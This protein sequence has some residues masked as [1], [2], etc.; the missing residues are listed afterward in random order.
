[1]P[2]NYYNGQPDYI[3]ETT[4]GSSYLGYSPSQGGQYSTVDSIPTSQMYLTSL[5][6]V[7]QEN[8]SNLLK[9]KKS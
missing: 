2:D 9:C 4:G 5:G 3:S 1:M 7:T 6:Q 8:N